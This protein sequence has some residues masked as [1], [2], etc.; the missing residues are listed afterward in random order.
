MIRISSHQGRSD[1]PDGGESS[2]LPS[3]ANWAKNPPTPAARSAVPVSQQQQAISATVSKVSTPSPKTTPAAPMVQSRSQESGKSGSSGGKGSSS[4]TTT[5]SSSNVNRKLSNVA[6]APTPSETT[7]SSSNAPL[8]TAAKAAPLPP[9]SREPEPS[10][11]DE[12]LQRFFRCQKAAAN[13]RFKFVFST[14]FL[15]PDEYQDIENIPPMF[16]RHGGKRRREIAEKL[17]NQQ[18]HGHEEPSEEISQPQP[19]VGTMAGAP[20]LPISVAGRGATPLQRD[21]L[22]LLKEAA[23]NQQQQGL[24]AFQQ[25]ENIQQQLQQQQQNSMRVHTPGLLH[26]Q[27]QQVQQAFNPFQGGAGSL[28]GPGQQSHTGSLH[29][30]QSSRYTFANENPAS[31]VTSVNPRGNAVHMAEQVRMMPQQAQQ[32]HNQQLAAQFYGATGGAP[33]LGGMLG[34]N[35][36][37]PPPGLKSAP[38][39]PAPGMGMPMGGIHALGGQF[40]GL[41]LGGHHGKSESS[42]VLLRELMR[43]NGAGGLTNAG[44][45]LGRAGDG[46]RMLSASLQGGGRYTDSPN[47]VDLGDPSILQARVAQPPQQQHQ[48]HHQGL[49]AGNTQGQQGAYNQ[50]MYYGNVGRW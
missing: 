28:G 45:G 27:Q 41:G 4:T 38:T 10:A 33:G 3:T 24:G 40:S 8:P 6:A 11:I 32:L 47:A 49:Q 35:V 20:G 19:P 29:A 18:D 17:R 23:V 48:M 12:H 44:S 36:Q 25:Q 34:G 16:D 43:G 26:Q 39:P 14:N 30:R 37:Q 22:T 9:K 46:K 31:A 1:T 13:P 5:S 7:S 2:A 50:N 15:S 42:E 21:P